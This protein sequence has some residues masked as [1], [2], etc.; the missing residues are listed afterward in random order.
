MGG[1]M[2][3]IDLVGALEEEHLWASG[4]FAFPTTHF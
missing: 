4:K 2:L 3:M 1:M